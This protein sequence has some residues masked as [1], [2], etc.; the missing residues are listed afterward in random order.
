VNLREY[1]ITPEYL[2]LMA[3]RA[4]QWSERFIAEQMEQFRRTIPDYPEVV[5]LLE[6]ELHRRRLNAL[7]KELR[8][9]NKDELQGRLQLMQRDFAAKAITQDELEVAETEWRIRNRKRLPEDY[10]PGMS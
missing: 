3:S 2:K 7:R 9:L 1:Y 8:L 5:D 10:R 6:G 4:R